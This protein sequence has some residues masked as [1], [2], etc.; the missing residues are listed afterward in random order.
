M[1]VKLLP[2]N[3]SDPERLQPLTTYLV[4]GAVAIDGGSLGYSLGLEQQQHIKG[5]VITHSHS[6]H[7]ASLP[8]FVSEIFPFLQE[9]VPVYGTP[10]V[11]DGLRTHVF[12]D[13]IWPDFHNIALLNGNGPGLVY[14][15]IAP[16]VPFEL[17]GLRIT[18]VRTNHIVPTVGMVVEDEHAAV[19]FTS[20]TYHTEEIWEVANRLE[21][22][23]AIYVDVSYP[24]EME[25]LAEV[26]KHLTPQGLDK[27]LG[28][29]NQQVPVIAVHL[30]PQFHQKV[31]EQLGQLNRPNV[32]AVR[33]GHEYVW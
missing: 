32:S 1:K 25:K 15:E 6:D 10:E 30:K 20:D 17:A 22:L 11:L 2:S 33:I 16:G 18:P 29:L 24:N 4:N 19:V 26:S 21:N 8:I 23:R 5:V 13:L 27:E 3:C 12:N 7:T 31:I 9:P 14:H 28:K